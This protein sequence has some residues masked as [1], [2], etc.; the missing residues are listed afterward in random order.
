MLSCRLLAGQ[1]FTNSW[2]GNAACERHVVGWNHS[3]QHYFTDTTEWME[4]N[5]RLEHA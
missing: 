4:Q 2:G 1:G 5:G 3:E